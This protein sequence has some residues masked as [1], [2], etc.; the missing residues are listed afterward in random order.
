MGLFSFI[1]SCISG[2]CSA[3]GSFVSGACSV[4]SKAVS[5]IASIASGALS[6]VLGPLGPILGPIV[7]NILINVIGKV[8]SKL[9][10]LLGITRKKEN[11]EEVGYRMDE[12]NRH[13]DWKRKE[14]FDSFQAYY[15]YLREQIP[16]EAIDPE[17]MKKN[18]GAYRIIGASTLYQSIGEE[19][20]MDL[21]GEFMMDIGRGRIS[22][23]EAKTILK[24]FKDLKVDG[25]DIS[26]YW[27]G[28]MT[29]QKE[30]PI[31]KALGVAFS[32]LYPEKSKEE[33]NERLDDIRSAT[34]GAIDNGD[35]LAALKRL[36][37]NEIGQMEQER[38]EI[39]KSGDRDALVE[40]DRV[41]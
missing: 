41:K 7:A 28:Y 29:F 4:F 33:I 12:A 22:A 8:I 3:I 40:F 13:D 10:Q 34:R 23:E 21:P 16:D 39:A 19:E 20:G 6:V 31:N 35:S 24:T 5:G 26:D 11:P 25:K 30:T 27:E 14:D 9:A 18:S 17:K 32:E 38:A 37:K 15:D 1:G 36:Y 2:V